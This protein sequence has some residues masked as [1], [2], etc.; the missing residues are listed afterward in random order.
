MSVHDGLDRPRVPRTTWVGLAAA[1]VYLVFAAVL[2]NVFGALAGDDETA[3]FVLSHY[4]PL[5]IAIVL[6]L[7]FLRYARWGR[8]VWAEA[9]T[10]TL[11]PRRW[12][13]VSIPVLMVLLPLVQ[14]P[15]TPWGARPFGTVLVVVIGTI[16]V[17]VGEEL[18]FR[19]ILVDAVR[20]RH[21]ELVT[22]LVTAIAFGLAHVVGSIWAG[23]P[24][25]AILFQVTFLAM[26]GSLYY[27][28]RRVSGRLWVAMA[29]HALTDCVLYLAAGPSRATDALTDQQDDRSADP[30]LATLQIL[31]IIAAVVGLVSAAREDRRTRRLRRE[32]T[33][34]TTTGTAT[35]G[36]P[37]T[38][39]STTG[40]P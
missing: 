11:R 8:G 17:G 16:L 35:T 27:W 7:V 31:L 3:E 30:L 39:T 6:G 26:N 14:L 28:V 5:P 15:A 25:A 22:L 2:G 21:G 10:P 13:L 23:V 1:A 36:T 37:A 24:A 9:P 33:A 38:G 19:G 29:V 4:I 34:D 40:R 18:F 12:W 32:Q 20:A